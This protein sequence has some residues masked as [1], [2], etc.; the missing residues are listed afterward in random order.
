MPPPADA[1]IKTM[2]LYHQ[3]SWV[4]AELAEKGLGATSPLKVGDL[5]PF[6]GMHYHGP[7]AVDEG[8]AAVGI[9][10][11]DL[12]MELGAGLG[13]PARQMASR[14]GC[15]VVAV[16]M[17]EDFSLQSERYTARCGLSDK[18][19]HVAADFLACDLATLGDGPGS[20]DHITS[21]LTFL[22]IEDKVA[23][24][25]RVA[26]LLKPGGSLYVEDFFALGAF[27]AAERESLASDVYTV[28]LPT[29]EEYIAV[30]SA[31]GAGFEV[32]FTDMT[33][34]WTAFVASR[35]QMWV[36]SRERTLRVHGAAHYT[37]RL[38]FFSAIKVLFEGGRLG[39]VRIHAKKAP[40]LH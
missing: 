34:S 21:W 7:A 19:Q 22:H 17:Q 29:R 36:D 31:A 16:E 30:L 6:D 12:V 5:L 35:T 23:L 2:R 32:E 25:G 37:A 10:P 14:T 33:G 9:Q 15:R 1:P 20:F 3:L 24:L 39:G 11:T 8:I 4:D 26:S 27:T 40:A 38:H 18:V 13:G 28:G